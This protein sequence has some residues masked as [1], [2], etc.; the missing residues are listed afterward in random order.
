MHGSHHRRRLRPDGTCFIFS[1]R[2]NQHPDGCLPPGRLRQKLG[3]KQR[4]VEPGLLPGVTSL[5][6]HGPQRRAAL[7]LLVGSRRRSG[8]AHPRARPEPLPAVGRAHHPQQ[9]QVVP[10]LLSHVARE[11]RRRDPAHRRRRDEPRPQPKLRRQ[12]HHRAARQRAGQRGAT[13][14][15]TRYSRGCSRPVNSNQTA[16]HLQ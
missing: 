6:E 4:P 12:H 16:G 14:E 3:A 2:E 13:E 5:S 1:V 11:R 10:L 15:R 9:H 7:H 8:A